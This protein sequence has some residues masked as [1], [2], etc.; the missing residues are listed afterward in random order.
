LALNFEIIY[1]HA[2]KAPDKALPSEMARISVK[3]LRSQLP[4]QRKR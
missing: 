1:G 2:F 4:S 3:D